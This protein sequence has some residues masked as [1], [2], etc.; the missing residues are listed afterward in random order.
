MR[1]EIDLG[2]FQLFGLFSSVLMP[3]PKHRFQKDRAWPGAGGGRA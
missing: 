3:N 1:F 2:S